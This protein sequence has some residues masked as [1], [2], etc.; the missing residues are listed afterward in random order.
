MLEC[1]D[2]GRPILNKKD[3]YWVALKD[4]TKQPQCSLCHED[5]V[6]RNVRYGGSGVSY[7]IKSKRK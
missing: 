6:R 7:A 1:K 3:A 4:L 5:D 2:C